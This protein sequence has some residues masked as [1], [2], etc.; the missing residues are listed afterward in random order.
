MSDDEHCCQWGATN[1]TRASAP[2][3]CE[4]HMAQLEDLRDWLAQFK[5][6]YIVVRS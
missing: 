2:K 4:A 6:G 1:G 3:V 5:G